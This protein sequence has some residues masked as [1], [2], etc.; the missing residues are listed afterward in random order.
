MSPG[1]GGRR[2]EY[3]TVLAEVWEAAGGLESGG[4]LLGEGRLRRG[5]LRG[6][7]GQGFLQPIW[8]VDNRTLANEFKDPGQ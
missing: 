7:L 4:R 5:W 6:T 8:R 2:R 1:T 3:L